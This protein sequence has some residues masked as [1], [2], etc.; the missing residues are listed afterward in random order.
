M[1]RNPKTNEETIERALNALRDIAP[2]TKFNNKSLAD[3]EPQ[4][5][6]SMAPRRRI[7]EIDNERSEQEAA[8]DSEDVKTLKMIDQIVAGVIGHDDY[9]K[10]SALYEALGF[11]RKSKRKS[12]LTRRKGGTGNNKP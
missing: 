11:V 7:G 3:L 9:G 12:G 6:K 2:D 8:R 10:D 4:A 5:E 1:G